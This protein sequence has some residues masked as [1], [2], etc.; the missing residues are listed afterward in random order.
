MDNEFSLMLFPVWLTAT[1]AVSTVLKQPGFLSP[2]RD[3]FILCTNLCLCCPSWGY[4]WFGVRGC[5]VYHGCLRLSK[6]AYIHNNLWRRL[7]KNYNKCCYIRGII[8]SS[9]VVTWTFIHV[10]SWICP[11]LPYC[12]DFYVKWLL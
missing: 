5:S 7:L 1:G 9:K 6:E 11:I 2:Q 12:N 10:Y 8:I 3:D 4:W